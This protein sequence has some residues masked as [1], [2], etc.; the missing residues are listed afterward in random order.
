[1]TAV[2]TIRTATRYEELNQD[3]NLECK[4]NSLG[5][6]CFPHPFS[7]KEALA[8]ISCALSFAVASIVVFEPRVALY[9]GQNG[10]F[11]WI[12]LCLTLMGWCAQLP[13][14]RIFLLL[15]LNSQTST[16]QSIDAVL[17]SDPLTSQANLRIRL[18]LITMLA[19][20]PALSAAYKSLGGE[21]Q[22]SQSNLVGHF[23]LSSP[24]G[25]SDIG[26]GLSQFVNA[27][28]PWFTNPGFLT[29]Y[30]ALIC[31]LL[32]KICLQC[33]ML[34]PQTISLACKIL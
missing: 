25:K 18:L 26:Y 13:L 16:L 14:R 17:R 6:P 21:S 28:L 1:M 15:S 31:M 4:S 12:S 7:W 30:M 11:I 32:Q 10:Q 22:Y 19:L 9:L 24:F 27:T 23:G 20:G 29:V 8:I 3:D 5:E 33:S 34:R 2:S